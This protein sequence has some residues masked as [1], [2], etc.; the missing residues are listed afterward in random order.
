MLSTTRPS[1][2]YLTQTLN[3]KAAKANLTAS[4]ETQA[5]AQKA[6]Q[7]YA[8]LAMV[9]KLERLEEKKMKDSD[10]DFAPVN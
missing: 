2:F 7:P 5:V 1:P 4:G 10:V 9:G 3:L 6:F 8:D